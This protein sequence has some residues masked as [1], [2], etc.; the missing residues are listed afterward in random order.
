MG[1]GRSAF[2][3]IQGFFEGG[4]FPVFALCLIVFYQLLLLALLLMPA[5]ETG[6]AAFADEFRV[7]CFGY[8]PATGSLEWGYVAG[9]MTPPLVLGA[10]LVLVWFEPLRALLRHPA[11]LVAPAGAAALLVAGA[12]GAFSVLGSTLDRG[13]LPF[14]AEAL[15]TSH[16]PPELRLT[17]QVGERVDLGQLRG[18]VV[19]LTGVY[20][21]C[22]HT[23]PLI[24]AQ[25]KRTIG[26][27][28]PEEQADLRVVAVTMDP[29]HDSPE[30]LAEL[31]G[32]HGMEAPLYNL[33]TGDANEVERILDAMGITRKRDPET[34]VIDHANLFLLVDRDGEVAYRLTLGELQERWLVSALELLLREPSD[35]D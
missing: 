23:C 16:R 4:G 19:M 15:R 29:A 26:K 22:P 34:D 3:R 30:V 28:T 6:L 13:E 1:E 10:V 11:A 5:G 17:N 33:V 9:M 32:M 2:N 25:A 35:V 31:A 8:D 24:L 21:S 14:P 7:W 12:A 20:A 27:L 18:K